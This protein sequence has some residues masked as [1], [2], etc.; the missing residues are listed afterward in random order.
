MR[1]TTTGPVKYGDKEGVTRYG[2]GEAMDVD[3]K[4]AAGL[5]ASGAAVAGSKLPEEEREDEAAKKRIDDANTKAAEQAK[6]EQARAAGLPPAP[7]VKQPR[8]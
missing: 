6:S 5:I 8:A 3:K 2:E 7:P 4:T 1:V